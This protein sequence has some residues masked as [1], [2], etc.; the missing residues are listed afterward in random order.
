MQ[1]INHADRAAAARCA[2]CAEALCPDCLVTVAGASY[3]RSCKGMAAKKPPVLAGRM[4]MAA[5][6]KGGVI[7]GL[8][9]LI[10]FTAVCGVVAIVLGVQARKAIAADPR[11]W[12]GGMA[13]AAICL[14]CIDLLF[15][16]LSLANKH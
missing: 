2:G 4:E 13:F 1:C 14:G 8:V 11:V 15:F 12:G 5:Q 9:G 3:C 7:I 16:V 6:A 10:L